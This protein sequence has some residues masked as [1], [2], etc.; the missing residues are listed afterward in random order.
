MH[1]NQLNRSINRGWDWLLPGHHG[2]VGLMETEKP[3]KNL[4]MNFCLAKTGSAAAPREASHFN[5]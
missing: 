1:P 3:S 4:V 5:W 2:A